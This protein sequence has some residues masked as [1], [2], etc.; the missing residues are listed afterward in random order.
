[1]GS[2]S[3]DVHR[4]LESYREVALCRPAASAWGGPHGALGVGGAHG[5]AGPVDGGTANRLKAAR[6]RP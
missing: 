1:M 5:P 4:L 6:F 3:L 2:P